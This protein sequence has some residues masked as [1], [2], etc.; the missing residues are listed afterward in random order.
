[1][2]S[3]SHSSFTECN[4]EIPTYLMD[5]HLQDRYWHISTKEKKKKKIYRWSSS[6][7]FSIE[8]RALFAMYC[9]SWFKNASGIIR[10]YFDDLDP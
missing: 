2:K 4:N 9:V 7:F 10:L 3:Q 5:C 8:G 1:M 6:C